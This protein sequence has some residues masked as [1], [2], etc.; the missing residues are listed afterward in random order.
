MSAFLI[1]HKNTVIH[2]D[3]I[4]IVSHIHIGQFPSIKMGVAQGDSSLWNM[5]VSFLKTSV[6][7][8]FFQP[9]VFQRSCSIIIS[10]SMGY[11]VE[12]TLNVRSGG[13]ISQVVLV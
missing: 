8:P 12:I 7:H 3:Y 1:F 2:S 10:E 9:V 5:H 11:I 4:T 6:T 13:Q